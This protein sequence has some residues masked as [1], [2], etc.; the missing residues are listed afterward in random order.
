MT[1]PPVPAGQA[2]TADATYVEA[3]S[4][5][6]QD[7]DLSTDL[8][9]TSADLAL[10][11][12]TWL[13]TAQASVFTTMNTDSVAIGIFD[14][15]RNADVPQSVSAA[16]VSAQSIPVGL[17]TSKVLT[18]STDTIL[19]IKA[20]RNG[21]STPHIGTPPPAVYIQSLKPQRISALKLK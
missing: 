12:G 9:Y 15:T 6:V 14:A 16:S 13:V 19:R 4:G 17:T 1:G 11:P 7:G 18:V 5:T 8:V 2:G 3:A 10:V 20:F 21:S